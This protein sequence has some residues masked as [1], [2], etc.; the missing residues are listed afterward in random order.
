MLLFFT[1]N[2][3]GFDMEN[4]RNTEGGVCLLQ[5][6]EWRLGKKG[7]EGSTYVAKIPVRVPLKRIPICSVT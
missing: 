3:R 5:E 4:G 1:N 2:I 6:Y 7:R